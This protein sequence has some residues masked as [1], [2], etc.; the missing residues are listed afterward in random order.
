MADS[1]SAS[2]SAS[3]AT[4]VVQDP[5]TWDVLSIQEVGFQADLDPRLKT[6]QIVYKRIPG[7]GWVDWVMVA[8]SAALRRIGVTQYGLYALRAFRGPRQT[9][10]GNA[11]GDRIGRYGGRILGTFE[12]TETP[13]ATRQI[14]AWA[15][16]S[17]TSMLLYRVNS[18]EG[19]SVIDG[20]DSGAPF[21]WRINDAR[22]TG[23][24]VNTRFGTNG[25]GY[26]TANVKPANLSTARTLD[27]LAASELLVSYE[28]GGSGFWRVQSTLG[29]Q[30]NP[31]TFERGGAECVLQMPLLAL[32]L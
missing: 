26:A 31:I 22:N 29:Q 3:A 24:S 30:D 21:L 15:R 1:A 13:A 20:H 12:N 14:E 18:G 23:R 28:A 6:V 27:D 2:A 9:R 5:D 11:P 32:K 25:F 16:E 17:R 19:I 10:L 4:G 8:Q 7:Q